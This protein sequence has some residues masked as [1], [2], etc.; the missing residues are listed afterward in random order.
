MGVVWEG[1]G[2]EGGYINI[3]AYSHNKFVLYVAAWFRISQVTTA[4]VLIYQASYIDPLT[5]L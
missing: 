1:R 5:H 2:G 4:V 3:Y